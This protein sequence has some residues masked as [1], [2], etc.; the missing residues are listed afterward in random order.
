MH[1]VEKLI[2]KRLASELDEES[3]HVYHRA[4]SPGLQEFVEAR[5]FL[6][7][8]EKRQVISVDAIEAE[9]LGVVRSE[10]AAAAEAA[11]AEAAAAKAAVAEAAAAEAAAAEAVASEAA[12]AKATA[13]EA[14]A[15][16]AMTAEPTING[17]N[18]SAVGASAGASA[19]V[20][21]NGGNEGNSTSATGAQE[22]KGL[23]IEDSDYLQGIA[24]L[25]GEMMRKAISTGGE[26]AMRIKEDLQAI[27]MGLA[28][29]HSGHAISKNFDAKMRVL[30]ES[31][32]KVEKTCFDYAVRR[33]EFG[34]HGAGEGSGSS[35]SARCAKRIA[36]DVGAAGATSEAKRQREG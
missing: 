13:T 32:A 22:V 17:E 29:L 4:F 36:E 35:G 15:A 12:A 14:T 9:L 30:K 28:P 2:M 16:H 3:Y 7:Y 5:T 8:C 34:T 6:S 11:A 1:R 19:S 18:T 25:T 20:T 26:E 31:V 21:A 33:A 23:K 24:D 27:E 10:K